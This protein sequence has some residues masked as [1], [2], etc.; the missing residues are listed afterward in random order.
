MPSRS[1]PVDI[2]GQ[3][4]WALNRDFTKALELPALALARA[5]LILPDTSMLLSFPKPFLSGHGVKVPI[6]TQFLQSNIVRPIFTGPQSGLSNLVTNVIC[7]VQSMAWE[8]NGV[9]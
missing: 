4:V 3:S 8:L 2:V 7:P 5:L 1:Y 6:A 9:D